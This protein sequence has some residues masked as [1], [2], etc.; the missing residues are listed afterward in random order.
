MSRGQNDVIAITAVEWFSVLGVPLGRGV[1]DLIKELV[2]LARMYLLH[3]VL[4]YKM[5]I[6]LKMIYILEIIRLREA[7]C[8]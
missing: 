5:F 7:Y 3:G 8:V 6:Q 4:F 1:G 2:V